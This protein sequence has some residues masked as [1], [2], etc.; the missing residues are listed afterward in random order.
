MSTLLSLDMM[1]T[2]CHNLKRNCD[3]KKYCDLTLTT[4][5]PRSGV[6]QFV[7]CHKLVLISASD[8]LKTILESN[9]N[10]TKEK[11]KHIHMFDESLKAF[12]DSS[13][14]TKS[15]G[16]QMECIDVSPIDFALLKEILSFIYIGQCQVDEEN[17]IKMSE[18]SI[19]WQLPLLT[20]ECFVS[21]QKFMN[22]NNV[23]TFYE[24]SLKYDNVDATSKLSHYI[25][26]HFEDI[27]THTRFIGL[28]LGGFTKLISS[29]EINVKNE[30]YIFEGTKSVIGYAMKKRDAVEVIDCLRLIRYEHFTPEYMFLASKHEFLNIKPQVEWVEDAHQFLCNKNATV[31]PNTPPRFWGERTRLAY[32]DHHHCI[33]IYYASRNKWVK[34]INMPKWISN[35][36][37]FCIR[38]PTIIFAS[39]HEN[40]REH[41]QNISL[42]YFDKPCYVKQLPE[43]P[44]EVYG[45]ALIHTGAHIYVI[46]GL[47]YDSDD[48]LQY[49]G[50][51]YRLCVN[52]NRW[53]TI[54]SI[55]KR[56]LQPLAILHNDYIYIISGIDDDNASENEQSTNQQSTV[57]SYNIQT[58]KWKICTHLPSVC[59]N[60]NAGIIIYN[61]KVTVVTAEQLMVYDEGLDS[62]TTK[63]Y[64][65]LSDDRVST[66]LMHDGKL[67]ASVKNSDGLTTLMSYNDDTNNWDIEP[68]TIQKAFHQ[69]F[70]FMI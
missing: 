21:M 11:N 64:T 56:M 51:M 63:R 41:G 39:T 62:W 5:N 61:G 54:Q 4:T 14:G 30:N 22:T 33:R 48:E 70:V 6:R 23:C 13:S 43:L 28:S 46:G 42:V 17:V 66:A 3:S 59:F 40:E 60:D 12:W 35:I 68:V 2:L 55:D 38:G 67:C 49:P 18:L 16:K 53:D 44:A 9:T 29:D 20:D 45:A 32:L 57:L 34:K 1:S 15:K 19:E 36:T 10:K 50:T 47:I 52:R 65:A 26:E 31:H 24:L 37:S 7:G 8:H 58:S 25:R 27:Y 69:R